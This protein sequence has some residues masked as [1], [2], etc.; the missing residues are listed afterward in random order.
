MWMNSKKKNTTKRK[1]NG[2]KPIPNCNATL[3]MGYMDNQ[4]WK[5]IKQG[6]TVQKSAKMYR[7]TE[8]HPFNKRQKACAF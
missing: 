4:V 2:W 8:I 3:Y 1:C 5:H 6:Q 7:K